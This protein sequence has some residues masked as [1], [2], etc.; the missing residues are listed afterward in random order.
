MLIRELEAYY[1]LSRV[2]TTAER[3]NLLKMNALEAYAISCHEMNFCE[4]E[5][6][7][8]CGEKLCPK[9]DPAHLWH[10]GCPSCSR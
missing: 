2:E 3:L 4:I 6:C 1:D 9:Q 10:D 5:E 7:M 8:W